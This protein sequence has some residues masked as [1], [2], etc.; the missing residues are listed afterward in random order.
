LVPPFPV[1]GRGREARDQRRSSNKEQNGFAVRPRGTLQGTRRSLC[2]RAYAFL[3]SRPGPAIIKKYDDCRLLPFTVVRFCLVPRRSPLQLYPLARAP[4]SPAR[5]GPSRILSTVRAPPSPYASSPLLVG[6][7]AEGPDFW[8]LLR[9]SDRIPRMRN[10]CF[11][12][13]ATPDRQIGV[14]RGE[15]LY[16]SRY[17]TSLDVAAARHP[18]G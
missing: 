18:R 16:A 8:G 12:L 6:R 5:P 11:V 10:R 1:G 4:C 2:P 15:I 7:R 14:R 9:R 17:S 13:A 3:R